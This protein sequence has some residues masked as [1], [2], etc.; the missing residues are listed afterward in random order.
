MSSSK[1]VAIIGAGPSGLV[2][3]KTLLHCVPAG[4]FAP[5]IFEKQHAIG[6]LWPTKRPTVRGLIDPSMRTNLSRFTVAFSDLAWE[7]VLGGGDVP[8]FPQAWQVNQYLATYAEQYLPR[9]IIRVGHEVVKIV[10][11]TREGSRP[12]WE[13][14]WR[15]TE[16]N[17]KTDTRSERFD[18]L[19]VASGYFSRPYVPD[20]PGLDGF[21][22]KTVHSSALSTP[23]DMDDLVEN[24]DASG[25]K[26][27]V[28][29]ASMSGVEAASALALH[30][31][32]LGLASSSPSRKPFEVHHVC[33]RP[34][35]TVPLYIPDPRQARFLP[36]DLAFYDL[37]RRPAGLVEYGYGRVSGQQA[38]KSNNYFRSLLG[39]DYECI[40]SVG[41][42]STNDEIEEIPPP[43]VAIGD[44]YAEYTRSGAIT[45]TIGRITTIHSHPNGRATVDIR[46]ETTND[47]TSFDNVAA[48]VMATGFTPY[49]SLSFLPAD[50]LSQLEY[51]TTDPFLPLVLDG[52]GTSNAAVP[53]LG[54]VGLYRGPYWGAME[55]QAR[56]L[57]QA[58]LLQAEQD[59]PFSDE[60]LARKNAEREAVRHVRGADPRLHRSQFPMGDYVGI[61]ESFA[62]DLDIHRTPLSD[63]GDR[64]GPVVPAR[65]PAEKGS[66]AQADI[67]VDSLRGVLSPDLKGHALAGAAA[68]AVFRAL[69]GTWRFERVDS[70]GG[71]DRKVR[72][73]SIFCPRYPS[74]PGCGRE[75][76]CEEMEIEDGSPRRG[77]RCVYGLTHDSTSRRDDPISISVLVEGDNPSQS[78]GLQVSYVPTD[79]EGITVCAVGHQPLD[80]SEYRYVFQFDGVVITS[81][82]CTMLSNNEDEMKTLYTRGT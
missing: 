70:R 25:G 41:V 18:F 26:V 14:Q 3:A 56:S 11:L 36:L 58:W 1:K 66:V 35:W 77:S 45:A 55:M 42:S 60:A 4:S 22:G 40:G 49:S 31:S 63:D 12:R 75:Y 71:R 43:W 23:E 30:L 16:W 34:F 38:K 79:R 44:D 68:T 61:M 54:F 72:G 20:I 21:T 10:R 62:R 32:S 19:I 64:S 52:K 67:V 29:G 2:A 6:G 28:T 5:V 59:V 7:S 33:S 9:E 51:S 81:W 8:M 82:E 24:I 37:G 15:E 50:V 27:V 53:E 46:N 76:V 74:R 78:M 65:Y 47:V 80:G 17:S 48:I 57:A 69:H 13:V 39:G 73:T